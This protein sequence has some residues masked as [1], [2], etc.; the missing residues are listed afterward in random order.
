MSSRKREQWSGRC[1]HRVHKDQKFSSSMSGF[2][3]VLRTLAHSRCRAFFRVYNEYACGHWPRH[4]TLSVS[5]WQGKRSPEGVR[6]DEAWKCKSCTYFEVT[7][8]FWS[9]NCNYFFFFQICDK[10]PLKREQTK[11]RRPNENV[12]VLY[13][14]KKRTLKKKAISALPTVPAHIVETVTAEPCKKP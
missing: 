2:I 14:N 4:E 11:T 5:Y 13:G 10:S 3:P 6:S 1:L 7:L 12:E 9:S 8:K